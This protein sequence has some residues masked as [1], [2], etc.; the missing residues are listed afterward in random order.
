[1]SDGEKKKSR[2]RYLFGCLIIF[3]CAAGLIVAA[4]YINRIIKGVEEEKEHDLVAELRDSKYPDHILLHDIETD[5]K[6]K[7]NAQIF[8]YEKGLSGR[9]CVGMG[10]VED[11]K[12]SIFSSAVGIF[13]LE[14]PGTIIELEGEKNN[15]ELYLP[16]SHTDEFLSWKVGDKVLFAGTISNVKLGSYKSSVFI[17]DVV[18][19]RHWSE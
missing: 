15:I 9:K 16:G 14:V 3:L 2:I 10:S 8:A 13:G 1:M 11:I 7:T 6:D 18:I 12:K 5:T 4:F 17:E 19:E